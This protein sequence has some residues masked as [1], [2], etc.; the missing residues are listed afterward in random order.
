[1]RIARPL[2]KDPAGAI[3]ARRGERPEQQGIYGAERHGIHA[4][5]DRQGEHGQCRKAWP[6][7]QGTDGIAKVLREGIHVNLDGRREDCVPPAGEVIYW[8]R[9]LWRNCS[10]AAPACSTVAI[11]PVSLMK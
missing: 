3:S 11:G 6:A 5:P 1:M 2:E 9:T 10:K 7:D 4:D 8:K